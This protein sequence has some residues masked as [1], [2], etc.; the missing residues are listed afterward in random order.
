MFPLSVLALSCLLFRDLP[1]LTFVEEIT[2]LSGSPAGTRLR[3]QPGPRERSVRRLHTLSGPLAPSFH[4]SFQAFIV[5][6]VSTPW[7]LRLDRCQPVGE[8]TCAVRYGLPGAPELHLRVPRSW[9]GLTL[10][11]APCPS[12]DPGPSALVFPTPSFDSPL[13]SFLG[14][15]PRAWR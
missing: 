14:Q 1:L 12:P 5:V 3:F 15:I 7:L 10:L 4:R 13:M 9:L 6:S 11:P 8:N 2:I